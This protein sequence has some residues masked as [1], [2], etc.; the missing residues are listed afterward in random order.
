M[1]CNIYIGCIFATMLLTNNNVA[2]NDNPMNSNE[3]IY[4]NSVAT[5]KPLDLVKN[6]KKYVGKSS[7]QIAG[8]RNKTLW[9]AEFINLMRKESGLKASTSNRAMDQIRN[10]RS[11]DKPIP[12]SILITRNRRGYHADIVAAVNNDNTVDLIRPNW[13]KKVQIQKN[14]RVSQGSKFILPD[15]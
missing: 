2:A 8:L 15:V 13:S 10:A 7:Y 4:V 9:C 1:K 6:A 5:G 14:V 12:G 3:I 11:I